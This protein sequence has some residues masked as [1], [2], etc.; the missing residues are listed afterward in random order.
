MRR[1]VL[2]P[3]VGV[4]AALVMPL[5]ASAG[6]GI[7]STQSHPAVA[8]ASSFTLGGAKCSLIKVPTADGKL[9][10]GVGSCP[11]V[12]PGGVIQTE[13]G[14]CTTNFLFETPDHERF[15]GTAG[16]CILGEGPV[17]DRAGEKLWPKGQG[18]VVKD[19]AGKRIGE[20]AYAV[21]QDP[22]D[23][24]LIRID[25]GVESNPEMCDFG[26]PNGINDDL[27][28]DPTVLQYFGNGIGI[29]TALP[30]RSAVAMGLPN[31]D[32]VFAAG[33]ALPGDSGSAVISEDGRAVGVLVTVGVHGFGIDENGG[34]DFGTV[35]IT[36]IAPQLARASQAL[37]IKLTMLT[38]K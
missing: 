37:G 1:S 34:I 16:H 15:I 30:A 28:G 31:P 22:K 19:G 13:I 11:G 4:L 10:V 21:L 27:S 35:G 29:G 7:A 8:R 32:H 38:V 24:A 5:A 17:A 9:P 12:R 18:S 25:P 23:F 2:M 36:R 3:V 14:Q 26:G 20:F 6:S 33:L